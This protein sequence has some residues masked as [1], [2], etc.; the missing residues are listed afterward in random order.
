MGFTKLDS[1]I[2]DSS[3][4]EESSDVLKLFITF[5]AKSN[6]EGIVS[7]TYNS[8]L[9]TSNLH[10][11]SFKQSL[12]ILLAPDPESRSQEHEGRRIIRLEESK[13][14]I[15]T[16]KKRR[17]YTYS[18]NPE[19]K[20]K[21]EYRRKKRD[22]SQSVP[23]HSASA[24]ASISDS[25]SDYLNK[26]DPLWVE[27]SAKGFEEYLK[28]SEPEWDKLKEDFEWIKEMRE[29]NPGKNIGLSMEKAW[30][31]F[32]GTK[33]GWE[34]KRKAYRAAKKKACKEKREFNYKMDWQLTIQKTL[35]YSLVHIPYGQPDHEKQSLEILER[36][37]AQESY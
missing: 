37:N 13:W 4:W 1:G 30:A 25:V 12:D 3:I 21:R 15:V 34:N 8:L 23:G 24:S 16:Y 6:S 20:R 18:D 9:R 31:Y 7:S 22:V 19:S 29:Y 28:I 10:P 32:W 11:E 17:E 27:N 2:I 36:K 35:K 14:L 5:W 33:A 26:E